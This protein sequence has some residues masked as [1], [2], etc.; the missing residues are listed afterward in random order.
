MKPTYNK[1]II[2]E[3]EKQVNAT[4]KKIKITS[5]NPKVLFRAAAVIIP[6][7]VLSYL[8]ISQQERINTSAVLVPGS[9]ACQ[10][11]EKLVTI[12]IDGSLTVKFQVS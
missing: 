5:R 3:T 9:R 6:L 1:S 12:G 7:V 8:S 10:V 11:A 4:V 2:R